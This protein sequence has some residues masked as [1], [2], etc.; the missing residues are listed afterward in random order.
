MKQKILIGVFVIILC[1]IILISNQ[2]LGIIFKRG[3]TIQNYDINISS[4]TL[5]RRIL[6][7]IEECKEKR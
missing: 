2:S 1:G 3:Y 7:Y 4:A 5:R 6:K